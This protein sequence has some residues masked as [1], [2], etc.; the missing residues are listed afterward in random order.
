M[1]LP[2][3]IAIFLTA[4]SFALLYIKSY[5]PL[6]GFSSLLNLSFNSSELLNNYKNA[7]VNYNGQ[8]I[9]LYDATQIQRKYER[10]IRI[11][12]KKIAGRERLLT[13]ITTNKTEKELK[14]GLNYHKAKLEIDKNNLNDF[15]K[16]TKLSKQ[17]ERTEI[18]AKGEYRTKK[19][20]NYAEKL[21]NKNSKIDN[22]QSFVDDEIIRKHIRNNKNLA[23]NRGQQDKHIEGTNNYNTEIKNG[24]N[25]SKILT[26]N[27][28]IE[29]I[30]QQYAGTGRIIRRADRSFNNK[31]FVII[32]ELLGI[33]VDEDT[34]VETETHNFIIHYA[35]DGVHIVPTK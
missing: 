16:Q 24:R 17:Y 23:L 9:S 18:S 11:D 29:K 30:V 21:Y 35:K 6:I 34:K 27:D 31:E 10:Q 8:E 2:F 12:K 20:V 14:A 15:L 13:S 25:P 1:I 22:L 7:K 4:K 33:D 26:N 19:V 28:E 3:T 5:I 32:K